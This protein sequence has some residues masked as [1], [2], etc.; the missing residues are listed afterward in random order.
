MSNS[1]KWIK[2]MVQDPRG[3]MGRLRAGWDRRQDRN[4]WRRI[5]VA[6]QEFYRASP[7][8]EQRLHELL[9]VPWPCPEYAECET[10]IQKMNR[11]FGF[12][13]DFRKDDS[14]SALRFFDADVTISRMAWCVTRHL[15]PERTIETGVARGVTS[16]F[17]LEAIKC[18]GV[19]KLWSIDLP[20]SDTYHQI[21][22]AVPENLRKS[23]KLILGSS[24]Q[25]LPELLRSVGT[26]DLFVHDSLHTSRNVRFELD[27]A[28]GRLRPGGVILMDD[29]HEN[30]GLQ[31]FVQKVQ[32]KDW[33][34]GQKLFVNGLWGAIVKP[35]R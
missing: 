33:V 16:R 15:T 9:G 28:W 18:N 23:W 1:A 8:P 22:S 14:T 32:A 11:E 20:H 31:S 29:V 34:V 12:G 17:L 25:R 2:I 13:E 24:Q 30:L 10:I 3:G 7:N 35:A 27:S 5:G 4:A 21:G 19:G 6:P 26:I